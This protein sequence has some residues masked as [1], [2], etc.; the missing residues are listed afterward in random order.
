M[1]VGNVI[2]LLMVYVPAVGRGKWNY[3]YVMCTT[4]RSGI[5]KLNVPALLNAWV[6]RAGDQPLY[7]A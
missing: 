1:V 7:N 6:Y 5:A 2:G 3:I 4:S